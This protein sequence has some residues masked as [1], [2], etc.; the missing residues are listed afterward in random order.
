MTRSTLLAAFVPFVLLSVASARGQPSASVPVL[1]KEVALD[2][3]ISASEWADA[4]VL[5]PA[6]R[7][8]PSNVF[9]AADTDRTTVHVKHD[10]RHLWVAVECVENQAGYPEAQAR[11]PGGNFTQDDCVQVVLGLADR[12]VVDRGVLD[13]GGYDGAM[14]TPAVAADNY[15]QFIVNAAGASERTWNELPL[16]APRFESAIARSKGGWSVEYRIPLESFGATPEVLRQLENDGADI[17]FNVLRYRP[18]Q[19]V[20]WHLPGFGGYRP[21]PFGRMKL[22]AAEDAAGRTRESPPAPSAGFRKS[23]RPDKVEIG[24][25]PL[26]GSIIGI[27][28][29]RPP[30]GADRAVLR[31]TGMPDRELALVADK[32]RQ[33][34]IAT[35]EKGDQPARSARLELFAKGA[36]VRTVER[37]LAAVTAPEWFGTDAGAAYIRERIP[38]PWTQPVVRERTVSLVDKAVRFGAFGLFDSIVHGGEELL[39]GPV[40]I[41]VVADGRAVSFSPQVPS[42]RAEGNAV[43]VEATATASGA[44]LDTRA[45]VDFDGFTEVK[46]RLRGLDPRTIS[47]FA[48][49]IPLRA[50]VARHTHRVLVQHVMRLDGFG[51]QGPAGPLWAGN[52]EH[53]L[54]FSSDTPVFFSKDVR[55]QTR[56]VEE[57]GIVWMELNFV[58][59]A[60]QLEE[61]PIF[62]FLLQP[63]PTKPRIAHFYRPTVT[64]KWEM[65]SDWQGYPDLAK[66]PELKAWGEAVTA[67]GRIPTLY[68]CQGLAEDSP[69]FQEFKEDMMLQPPW[70]FYRRHHNPGKGVNAWATSKRGPEGDLQ[71]WAFRKLA[72]EA[73]VAGVLSDGL[74]IAWDDENPGNAQGGG[75]PVEVTWDGDVHSR[76][77]A[78]RTFLKRLRGIFH[79]TGRPLAMSSHTGGGLDPHTLSFFDFYIDGEQLS[80]FPASYQPPL[81][82][83]AIGYSGNPW[84]LRGTFWV[85]G[86]LKSGGPFWSLTYALLHDNEVRDHTLVQ[87]IL[88]EF[89]EGAA[90][91]FHPYWKPSREVVLKSRTGDSRVSY[92]RSDSRVLVV[93]GNTGLETDTLALDFR[94]L[95]AGGVSPV[96]EDVLTGSRVTLAEGRGEWSLP[97]GHCVVLRVLPAGEADDK[98]AW[99]E[100][101]P[102]D[103]WELAGTPAGARLS[104]ATTA[105]GVP[106]LELTSGRG[107]EEARA[108][109]GTHALG[110]DGSAH[111]LIEPADRLRIYLGE[112]ALQYT[113]GRG[114]ET[115]GFLAVPAPGSAAPSFSASLTAWPTL[116][117]LYQAPVREDGGGSL[118]KVSVRDGVVDATFDGRPLLR[119]VV[120]DAGAGQPFTLGVATWGGSRL[121]FAP[122]RIYGGAETLYEGGLT[123][124]RVRDAAAPGRFEGEAIPPE[125]WTANTEV[126]GVTAGTV[127]IDGKPAFALS[128]QAGRGRA[129]ATLREPLGDTFSAVLTLARMPERLTLRIGAVSLK[130]DGRWVLDG[131]RDGWGRGRGPL[132]ADKGPSPQPKVAADSAVRM[133]VSMKDGVLD[134]V[135]N[136][137]LLVREAAFDLPRG[138][139]FLS[140]ETWAGF[141]ATFRLE[142]LSSEPVVLFEPPLVA[143]PVL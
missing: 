134:M 74:S 15:Y 56:L 104:Q 60:G 140:L 34:V 41:D 142:R 94:R 55:R 30:D 67:A 26:L 6:M 23:R 107:R 62:R 98:A 115:V 70:R 138:G 99:S 124:V 122:V 5:H 29:G 71:L 12:S 96:V 120:W 50:E 100:P 114:W 37:E 123:S 82:N 4:A 2:G 32:D 129:I 101:R 9:Q 64:D 92:Y 81:A 135:V 79:D 21:M 65:W 78:Q 44:V 112:G 69:G 48:V 35:I 87:E 108:H 118:L 46:L 3:K 127:E 133:V 68:T 76:L 39:A 119:G 106:A 17:F 1:E 52:E 59:G 80:R 116:G 7:L 93:A 72:E 131:P 90:P 125:R 103:G 95:F 91:V 47:R 14:G 105:D 136:D 84:G 128:S 102:V 97:R 20:G 66:L 110:P 10:G 13:M 43:R 40:K 111:L 58:D 38:P 77:V 24:Y 27:I 36:V 121:V 45:L 109:Y 57:G 130:Y 132:T 31:V 53:G 18:P 117:T 88:R 25:Y 8:N 83:Y 86:W 75:Y 54:S 22:L 61:M 42:L 51:F 89:G 137:Q 33:L 113:K 141:E 28:D 85:K 73:K 143:H 16:K 63:T 126:S 11:K 49:R 139:N 19:M